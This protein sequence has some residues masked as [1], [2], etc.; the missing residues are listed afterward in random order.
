MKK[1]KYLD[2][3]FDGK[4]FYGYGQDQHQGR[5]PYQEDF[6]GFFG[7]E[8]QKDIEKYGLLFVLADGMGGTSKGDI[9]SVMAV[10]GMIKHYKQVLTDSIPEA[11]NYSINKTNSAIFQKG[12]ND[13]KYWKMGTTCVGIVIKNGKLFHVSAGDSHLY[14][15][16]DGV[17]KRLNDEHSVG[18]E[19]DKRADKG[20]ITKKQALSS[21]GRA[22]LTSFLGD[23]AISKVD[24]SKVPIS[25]RKGDK[26]VICSDGLYGF[27]DKKRISQIASKF[28]PQKGVEKLIEETIALNLS[29][30]DNISIQILEVEGIAKK[31]EVKIYVR[32]KT[33]ERE[34]T[35][36]KNDNYLSKLLP[37]LIGLFLLIGGFLG[38]YIVNSVTSEK[39]VIKNKINVITNMIK[40]KSIDEKYIK[41]LQE[42][43]KKLNEDFDKLKK[44]KNSLISKLDDFKKEVEKIIKKQENQE[45][46]KKLEPE[47]EK[48]NKNNN[49]KNGETDN[50][51]VKDSKTKRMVIKKQEEKT[52][53]K[54]IKNSR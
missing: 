22:K 26:I 8:T 47:A 11:L 34:H 39:K 16:R 24:V 49:F 30:Q 10:E 4:F 5:R 15:I 48:E 36:K 44:D 35:K 20:L 53:Q 42:K 13:R 17:L 9:A 14:L 38:G 40:E 18:V 1:R 29:D 32:E 27:L 46:K 41:K 45:I 37:I 6:F 19:L 43:L 31:S 25:L 52:P 50:Q 51:K 54:R 21:P 12:L 7:P 2:K 33:W 3:L 23:K 28:S